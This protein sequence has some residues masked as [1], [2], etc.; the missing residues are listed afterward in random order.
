MDSGAGAVRV[1]DD[2][3]VAM[4]EFVAGPDSVGAPRAGTA[5]RYL[6]AR[7]AAR[8][9]MGRGAVDLLFGRRSPSGG[10]DDWCRPL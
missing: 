2:E 6:A 10:V 5:V 1:A 8:R 3:R 9:V 7:L 4:R